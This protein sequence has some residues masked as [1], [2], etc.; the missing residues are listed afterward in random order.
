MIYFPIVK[1][2]KLTLDYKEIELNTARAKLFTQ[3]EFSDK[4]IIY[5]T[6]EETN[7]ELLLNRDLF[8][9][10][11]E[12]SYEPVGNVTKINEDCQKLLDTQGDVLKLSCKY[13]P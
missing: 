9:K 7:I 5:K 1:I 13:P 12:E 2:I 8:Y 6:V 11:N 4:N 3:N 10:S